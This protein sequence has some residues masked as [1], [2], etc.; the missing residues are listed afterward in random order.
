MKNYWAIVVLLV[1]CAMLAK[2]DDRKPGVATI[3]TGTFSCAKFNSYD[4]A[5][6]N[7]NQMNLIVQWTWGFISAYNLRAA[8]SAT[9][10]EAEAPSPVS[11]PDA[12]STL[13]FIRKFCQRTPQGNLTTATLDL[14]AAS[15]GI[16]TSSVQQP[17]T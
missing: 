4:T 17:Q 9:F 16:V 11:P 6:N 8:F 7:S 5:P 13:Q 10:Q 3:G 12:A 1:L 15:G 2:S 14:I